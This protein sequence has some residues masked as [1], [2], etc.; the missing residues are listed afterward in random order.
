M[1]RAAYLLSKD[2]EVLLAPYVQ[3][4]LGEDHPPEISSPA[5]ATPWDYAFKDLLVDLK[6]A[7]K[8]RIYGQISDQTLADVQKSLESGVFVAIYVP[9]KLYLLTPND[10]PFLAQ[11]LSVE[12]LETFPHVFVD[13]ETGG[14][15]WDLYSRMLD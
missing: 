14:L 2:A 3:L 7:C 5:F 4:L 12:T 8:A 13:P 9:P 11:G 10:L 6:L 15:V 1:T